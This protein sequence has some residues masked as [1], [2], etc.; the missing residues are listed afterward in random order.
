MENYGFVDIY[1]TKGIEYLIVIVFLAS[2][3]WFSR[4]FSFRT[5]AA[6]VARTI[7]D[8]VEWFRMPAGLHYHQ[9]HSWMKNEED[10]LVSVG[11]D[12]FAQKLVGKVDGVDLPPVGAKVAQGERAWTLKVDSRPLAMLSPVDGEVVAVNIEAMRSPGIVNQDP[13]G[14]GWLLKIRP[15]KLTADT[16]NLL[17][18][19]LA[20]KW[21]EDTV[22]GLRRESGGTLGP[23]AQD[24]GQLV[25]QDGGMPVSGIAR[26]LAGERWEETV[27]AHFLTD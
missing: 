13:Y 4:T 7:S 16:R 26:A 17:S 8:I 27:K 3:V 12:D 22:D 11:L 10:D 1:A 20:R 14:K 9:G 25:Y 6:G 21:M 2:F 23:V 19:T 18:G 5:V 24:G 15:T